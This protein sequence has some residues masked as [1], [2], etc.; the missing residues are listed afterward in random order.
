MI[1]S[2]NLFYSIFF[3]EN[4]DDE[5]DEGKSRFLANLFTRL[6]GLKFFREGLFP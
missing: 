4:D 3:Q 2:L 6:H 5:K 1:W